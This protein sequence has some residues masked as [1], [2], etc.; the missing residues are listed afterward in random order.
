[1]KITAQQIKNLRDQT[2]V[3]VIQCK[4]A[5]EKAEGDT[6]KALEILKK[7]SGDIAAK[8]SERETKDGFI[9]AKKSGSPTNKGIILS[10]NCETDFVSKNEEFRAVAE[11]LGNIAL[12][13]GKDRAVA[14]AK[15]LINPLVQKIGEN[16]KLG[17]ILEIEGETLGVYNH[18]GKRAVI[19]ALSGVS[20]DEELAR[21]LAMQTAAMKPEYISLSEI[22]EADKKK[23]EELFAPDV[24]KLDKP[25]EMK[26]KVLAGKVETFLKERTLLE[27]NF[28]KD[29]DLKVKDLLSR[30]GK[31]VKVEKFIQL[32]L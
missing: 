24:S 12:S 21:D 31:E 2:G 32:S 28:I 29:A 25:E 13:E 14:S 5:L 16:I 19:L 3:S 7:L 23:M 18:N 4:N 26:K 1:M 8:K 27:Q 10:L 17:Q 11:K 9:V 6:E 20:A 30:A 15:A 22:P